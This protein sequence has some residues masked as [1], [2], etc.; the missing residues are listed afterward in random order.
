[1][2]MFSWSFHFD[3]KRPVVLSVVVPIGVGRPR[4]LP[5]T[6]PKPIK[7]ILYVGDRPR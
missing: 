2:V 4:G 1:M 3:Y 7:T 5:S 6:G